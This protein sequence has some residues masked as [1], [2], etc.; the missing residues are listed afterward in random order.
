MDDAPTARRTRISKRL[1][2]RGRYTGFFF[3]FVSDLIYR[4]LN[5]FGSS[6]L[7]LG[8]VNIAQYLPLHGDTLRLKN[9]NP[10]R[11]AFKRWNEIRRKLRSLTI[12]VTQQTDLYACPFINVH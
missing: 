10:G 6:G 7:S 3:G 1:S 12:R 11:Q 9:L 4:R 8:A 2:A 5:V